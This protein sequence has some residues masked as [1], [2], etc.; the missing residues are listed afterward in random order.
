[1]SDVRG[2]SVNAFDQMCVNSESSSIEIDETDL[3]LEE[4]CEQRM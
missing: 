2:E 1:M 4:H 3:Q